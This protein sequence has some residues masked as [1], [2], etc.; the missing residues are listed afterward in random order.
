MT[1]SGGTEGLKITLTWVNERK[2]NSRSGCDE[3]TTF[4]HSHVDLLAYGTSE[5]DRIFA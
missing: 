5:V 4:K 1:S 3:G 2:P